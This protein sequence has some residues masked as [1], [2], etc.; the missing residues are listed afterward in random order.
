VPARTAAQN[1][2]IMRGVR[3]KDTR[4]E[5]TVRRVVHGLGYR[6]RL[7]GAKLPGKPDLVF[8]NR[9]SVIFVHGCFWHAHG[10][11]SDRPPRTRVEFWSEKL[12]ANRRRDE[13]NR[14]RLE[15]LG[16]RVLVV[17]ECELADTEAL[18]SRLIRFLDG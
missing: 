16:W 15:S 12:A 11:G 1:S 2:A 14:R 3:H 17:W 9:R 4:P 18:Q 7:H 8:A 13:A 10:C 6:Y 5:W